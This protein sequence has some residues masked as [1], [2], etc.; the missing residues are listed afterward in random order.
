MTVRV[1]NQFGATTE[2]RLTDAV[3]GIEVVTIGDGSG[4]GPE[5]QAEVLVTWGGRTDVL[6]EVLDHGVRWVHTMSTGVDRFPFDV[7][8]DRVLT[9]SRGASATPIAE[10]VMAQLL[11]HVKDL[12]GSWITEPPE[13]WNLADLSTLAGRRLGVVGFGAIGRAVARRAMAFDMEVRAVRRTEGPSDV[14]GVELAASVEDLATWADDLVLAAPATPETEGLVDADLLANVRPGLHLVNIARG[15]LV[16]Q[17]ALRPAL[18]DGRVARASLD[19][20]TP[21]PLPEGHWLY[22]HPAVNLSAHVSWSDPDF[23]DRSLEPLV[24]NLHRWV[25]GEPLEGVVDPAAGY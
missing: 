17:D 15:A 22:D 8:G 3:D 25:A 9:N 7:L 14:G 20:V 13:N 12:P 23:F 21:E 5:D 1:F 19:T 24:A 2:R 10:W 11:A 16:D 4:L 18:D 6:A